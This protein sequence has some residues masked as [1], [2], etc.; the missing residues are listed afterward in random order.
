VGGG[1]NE[2]LK[3][4]AQILYQIAQRPG[5][6]AARYGGEEFI[7]LLNHCHLISYDCLKHTIS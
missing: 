5:D 1:V 2:C 4:V 3:E 7:L 6:L